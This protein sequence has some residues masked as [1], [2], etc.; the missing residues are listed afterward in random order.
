MR[1]KLEVESFG[2]R[3]EGGDLA[4]ELAALFPMRLVY[5]KRTGAL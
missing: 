2:R 3:A 5:V 1:R 4:K